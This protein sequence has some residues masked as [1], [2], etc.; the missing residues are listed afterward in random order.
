MLLP[1]PAALGRADGPD[2]ESDQASAKDVREKVKLFHMT[3]STAEALFEGIPQLSLRIRIG[4]YGDELGDLVS[5]ASLSWTVFSLVK[6]VVTF[7]VNRK[8]I[9]A[10]FSD[11]T[12]EEVVS[13]R[14]YAVGDDV[15]D[16]EGV[17]ITTGGGIG[18]YVVAS[19]IDVVSNLDKL[20]DPSVGLD[21]AGL[22]HLTDGMQVLGPTGNYGLQPN[23][24]PL[25]YTLY[26]LKSKIN[27][28]GWTS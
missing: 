16:E 8:R 13:F 25:E 24:I 1:V 21:L 26:A 9:W 10:T 20:R 11:L 19:P 7:L 5:I 27:H 6:A 14:V 4:I 12:A 18:R 15:L 17:M 3:A 2:D 23:I 22:A 28:L